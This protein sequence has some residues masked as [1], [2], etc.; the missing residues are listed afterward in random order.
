MIVHYLQCSGHFFLPYLGVKC[1]INKIDL[2]G[3][4]LITKN[5]QRVDT[6]MH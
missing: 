6:L 3:K 4:S 5:V 1:E 2:I